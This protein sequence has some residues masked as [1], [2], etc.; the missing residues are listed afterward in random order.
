MQERLG[1]RADAIRDYTGALDV[2]P[3]YL[4]AR[5][6]RGALRF[7]EGRCDLAVPDLRHAASL[8]GAPAYIADMLRRCG[9][10]D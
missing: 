4:E 10:P 8:G 9:A 3:D 6:N 2:Y 1:A 7:E 5:V